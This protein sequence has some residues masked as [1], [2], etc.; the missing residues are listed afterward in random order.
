MLQQWAAKG[1][2]DIGK[3]SLAPTWL[4]WAV[5]QSKDKKIIIRFQ[6]FDAFTSIVFIKLIYA[7]RFRDDMSK[8]K[9]QLTH[10]GVWDCSTCLLLN[11]MKR[12]LIFWGLLEMMQEP[13]ILTKSINTSNRNTQQIDV[14]VRLGLRVTCSCLIVRLAWSVW[15]CLANTTGTEVCTHADRSI[16]LPFYDSI[17]RSRWACRVGSPTD[18]WHRRALSWPSV[19]SPRRGRSV[20]VCVLI[21]C[22]GDW[23]NNQMSRWE[24]L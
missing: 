1:D 12:H 24:K 23:Q 17:E 8:G 16:S 5:F 11:L 3:N 10:R 7:F 22:Q 19:P 9:L 15:F 2:S 20:V 4:R 13:Q 14:K 6:L 21:G 18:R